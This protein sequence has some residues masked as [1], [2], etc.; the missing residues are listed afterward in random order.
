MT[1]KRSLEINELVVLYNSDM[2]LITLNEVF[3]QVP[4]IR[5]PF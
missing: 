3:R 5:E 4:V 1:A 2:H